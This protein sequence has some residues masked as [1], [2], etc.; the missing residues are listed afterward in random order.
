MTA[1]GGSFLDFAMQDSL[2]RRHFPSGGGVQMA[3]PHGERLR[4]EH[5]RNC[6]RVLELKSIHVY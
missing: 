3:S 6:A 1:R 5:L 4:A 2:G